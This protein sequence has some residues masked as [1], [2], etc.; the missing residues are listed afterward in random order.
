MNEETEQVEQSGWI[1]WLFDFEFPPN[2]NEKCPEC[3]DHHQ[4]AMKANKV[5]SDHR[6]QHQKQMDK[7][8]I[9]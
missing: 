3:K 5:E 1:C 7:H 8:F 2:S 4:K 9:E 6:T